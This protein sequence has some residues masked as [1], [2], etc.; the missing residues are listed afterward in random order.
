MRKAIMSFAALSSLAAFAPSASAQQVDFPRLS[1]TASV[2]QAVGVTKIELSYS[3]PGV[4]GRKIWGELVPYGEV[5]RT[6]ANENTTISFSTP[7]KVAGTELPAGTYGLQTIPTEGDWT[8]IL[9]KDA[10]LWGAFDYKPENDALRATVTPRKSPQL[11][12][13][14]GFRFDD[15]TDESAT[16][17]LAWENVE[18]P[19]K[20]EVD[21]PKLVLAKAGESIRWQTGYQA[22]NYCLQN[23]TCL[24]EAGRW[25]TSS[26]AIQENF[27]NLRA[28]ALW[29]SK[30]GDLKGAVATGEK[31]LAAAKSAQNPPPANLVSELEG[32]M[33]DWRAKSPRR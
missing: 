7:V 31:A 26:L 29:Q 10:E 28:K 21:T 14:M 32:W 6:G 18:V 23:D 4:K 20:I 27:F 1:P 13:R 2:T 24:D 19:F 11:E 25:L 30:K 9:S 15:L 16:V 5:W 33:K 8:L 12:E 17:V 22:A 3:R